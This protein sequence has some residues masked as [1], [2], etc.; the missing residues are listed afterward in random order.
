MAVITLPR[1]SSFYIS[2][3]EFKRIFI[4]ILYIY[5][6]LPKKGKKFTK[7]TT[8]LVFM[9]EIHALNIKRR[10]FLRK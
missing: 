5:Q 9:R 3:R 2:I 8:P 6:T 1:I 7:R 4:P 10:M